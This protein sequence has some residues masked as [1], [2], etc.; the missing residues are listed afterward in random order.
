MW[1][2]INI[3]CRESSGKVRY[4]KQ[5]IISFGQV[6]GWSILE[7]D[8][9]TLKTPNMFTVMPSSSS[10]YDAIQIPDQN[11][12]IDNQYKAIIPNSVQIIF[13][14]CFKNFLCIVLFQLNVV[15]CRLYN[16]AIGTIHNNTF[17]IIVI[18]VNC[19]YPNTT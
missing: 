10:L 9:E 15:I 17:H 14:L 6:D 12:D 5:G 1:K 4:T 7:N 2:L 13:R 11:I 18:I 8:V 19:I 3:S 16:I